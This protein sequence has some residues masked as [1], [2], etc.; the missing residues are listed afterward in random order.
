MMRTGFSPLIGLFSVTLSLAVAVSAQA[1]APGVSDMQIRPTLNAPSASEAFYLS[2]LGAG[3]EVATIRPAT[4]TR[5]VRSMSYADFVRGRPD[6][7]D[8]REEI[9]R[10]QPMNPANADE[11]RRR[12]EESGWVE[13]ND[14]RPIHEGPPSEGDDVPAAQVTPEPVSTAL[15]GSGLIGL[16]W[17][18]F[19]KRRTRVPE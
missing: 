4:D 6:R 16:A 17:A 3:Q 10:E 19:R 12:G 7:L 1:Q 11:H 5:N 14:D 13:R 2:A 18:R 8:R 15:V 9:P